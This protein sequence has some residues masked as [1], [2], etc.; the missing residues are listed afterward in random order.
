[1]YP[2]CGYKEVFLAFSIHIV[3]TKKFS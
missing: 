3:A 2:Y 1:L